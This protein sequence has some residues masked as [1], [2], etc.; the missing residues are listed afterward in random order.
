MERGKKGGRPSL[1][2][3]NRDSDFP[4]V[5]FAE[6]EDSC[7]ELPKSKPTISLLSILRS[8]DLEQNEL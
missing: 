2:R 3:S 6:F 8:S 1:D 5:V 7:P 4:C